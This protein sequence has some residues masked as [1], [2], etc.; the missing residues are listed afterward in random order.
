MFRI[1]GK[2]D[3]TL[4]VPKKV[5]F[6]QHGLMVTYETWFCHVEDMPIPF[7]LSLA[8]YDVWLGNSRGNPYSQRHVSDKI[9]DKDY[10]DFNFYHMGMYDLPAALDFITKTTGQEKLSYIGCSQGTQ[11]L[12]TA[13][14]FKED[15]FASKLNLFIAFAPVTKLDNA[16]DPFFTKYENN[17]KV[18]I[19]PL[20]AM[21]VHY[22]S[23]LQILKLLR[24]EEKNLATV[25]DLELNHQ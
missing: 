18:F 5:V 6:L 7:Q 12:F 2:T 1:P 10:W 3:E 15:Y 23:A 24:K 22:F 17:Y 9:S 16:K 20:Q 14:S 21:G 25:E 13:L 11:Q 4:N 8:G 19:R